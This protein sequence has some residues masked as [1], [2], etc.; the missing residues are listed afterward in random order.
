M[1]RSANLTGLPRRDARAYPGVTFAR[2]RLPRAVD[3]GTV[4]SLH[5]RLWNDDHAAV[6]LLADRLSPDGGVVAQREVDPTP[7]EGR[8]RLQLE[9]LAGL[10]DARRGPIGNLPEL[11][12]PSA[13]VALDVHQ[14]AGPLAHLT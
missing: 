10:D 1:D 2:C 13:A 3:S 14:D 12:L 7:L 9:H 8:H 11:L 4:Q 6:W 5:H